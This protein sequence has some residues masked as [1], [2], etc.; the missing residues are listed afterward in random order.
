MCLMVLS[1][2]GFGSPKISSVLF[3]MLAAF[4]PPWLECASSMV[5]AKWHRG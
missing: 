5:M 1:A 2:C 4:F 3:L